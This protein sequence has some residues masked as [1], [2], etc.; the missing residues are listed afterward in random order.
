MANCS[1]VEW[2]DGQPNGPNIAIH[3]KGSE[4]S[5]EANWER[6][7]SGS[8]ATADVDI[9]DMALTTD[10]VATGEEVSIEDIVTSQETA[11]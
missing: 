9:A 6:V 10:Q 7:R 3:A 8:R 11:S 2:A 5:N 1:Q 4:Y